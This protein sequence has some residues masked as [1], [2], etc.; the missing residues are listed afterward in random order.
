[1]HSIKDKIVGGLRGAL[2]GIPVS[3]Q[4]LELAF[5]NRPLR[6]I[7]EHQLEAEHAFGF[8]V[9]RNLRARLADLRD[10]PTQNE[11]AGDPQILTSISPGRISVAL[12]EGFRLIYC[13]N[14]VTNPV[15]DRGQV[16]WGLV[17]RLK[18]LEIRGPED[19]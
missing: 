14:H 1:M 3:S 10:A 18:V 13:A 8:S 11:V 2:D 15:D 19:E 17:D 4:S 5:A 12:G 6:D 16:Q 7:C 9:A